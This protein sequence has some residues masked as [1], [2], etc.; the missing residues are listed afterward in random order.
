MFSKIGINATLGDLDTISATI[1]SINNLMDVF[2]IFEKD[3]NLPG[4]I[5]TINNNFARMLPRTKF[6]EAMSKQFMFELFSKRTVQSFFDDSIKDKSLFLS[7]NTTILSAANEALKREEPQRHDPIIVK[8]NNGDL[9]LLDFHKLL[10]AQTQVHL[11]TFKSLKEANEFKR[12]VLGMAAHDL[13]NPINAIL[14]FSSLLSD[15]DTYTDD[16]KT[17]SN[18]IYESAHQMNDLLNDLLNSAANDATDFVLNRNE[19]DLVPLIDNIIFSFQQQIQSK[20]Q[21][22]EFGQSSSNIFI[23][24]DKQKIKEVLENLISNAIKY[25]EKGK[26]IEV[27]TEKREKDIFIK[28]KDYG[29]G[30]NES[31]LKNIFKRFQRLSAKPTG[32][33]PST[34]LGLYI[35]K[36]IIDQHDGIINIETEINKGSTFKIYLPA[37]NYGS[38]R[39]N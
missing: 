35:V 26:K 8:F 18:Y 28:I 15:I 24:A 22:L 4:I 39:L 6:Y 13:R 34:G 1:A 10:L 32:D 12:D 21:S 31:D 17:Y 33:E 19:F 9:R 16:I 20:Q 36:R 23:N 2:N 5:V 30:F 11:L 38:N 25:S 14:G 27:F 37:M 3:K 29:P 7:E